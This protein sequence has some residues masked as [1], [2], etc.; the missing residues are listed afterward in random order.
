MEKPVEALLPSFVWLGR[1]KHV[2][3]KRFRSSDMPY[4]GFNVA[5]SAAEEFAHACNDI[6]RSSHYV[7]RQSF[8]F[9]SRCRIDL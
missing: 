5:A 7:L 2:S 1:P 8:H 3:C 9:I 4:Y 6:G